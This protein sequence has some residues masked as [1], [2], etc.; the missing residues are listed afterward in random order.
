MWKGKTSGNI[1]SLAVEGE[2][3]KDLLHYLVKIISIATHYQLHFIRDLCHLN[4]FQHIRLLNTMQHSYTPLVSDWDT[5]CHSCH[6]T[7]H[8]L[9]VQGRGISFEPLSPAV[10]CG[11]EPREM[12]EGMSG[13]QAA[14]SGCGQGKL[15]FLFQSVPSPCRVP[16]TTEGF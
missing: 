2:W 12:R 15:Q 4:N 6:T 13:L 10:L 5:P 11:G 3:I 16:R 7:P 8:L 9:P 1:P 14:G